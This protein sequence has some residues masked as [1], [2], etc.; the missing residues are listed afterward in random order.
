MSNR[1][2]RRR[3]AGKRGDEDDRNPLDLW[4]EGSQ[5]GGGISEGVKVR[6]GKE[7]SRGRG[8]SRESVISSK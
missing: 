7:E 1:R 4:V 8:R 5:V 6:K 2:G 3:S